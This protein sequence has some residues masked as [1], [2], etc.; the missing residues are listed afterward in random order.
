VT[1]GSPA[2]ITDDGDIGEERVLHDFN[3]MTFQ[4]RRAPY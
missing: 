4:R 3:A 1:V 2:V